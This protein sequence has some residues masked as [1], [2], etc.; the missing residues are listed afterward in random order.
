MTF[1]VL[2]ND[3]GSLARRGVLMTCHGDVQTPVFMP[4]GTQGT[5]KAMA[6]NELEEMGAEIILGNTY[7]LNLRPGMD[8]MSMAGG[9]HKFMAWNRA[10]LTDSGG[11]QVFSLSKLNKKTLDGVHFQSHIDGTP[12]FMGPVESMAIQRI[13]GSDIAM[14][15]DECT[16]YPISHS[17]AEK[18]LEMTLRWEKISAE[19]P[20]GEGQQV[21]GIV[22]GSVY[23]D[24]RRHSIEELSKM[25]FDGIA[26]GGVSVGESEEE[27]VKVLRFCGPLLPK[28]KPH[29]LMGVGTP[30]QIIIGVLNGIDMFDCV[31]PT[32]MGRNGSAYTPFGTIPIKAGRYK[33]DFS[34]IMEGCQCYACKHFTKAYI[35][36]LLNTNEILGSRLMSIHNLHYFINLMREIRL[37]LEKGTFSQLAEDVLKNYPEMTNGED[38]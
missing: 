30:R 25:P 9:L 5:V 10:I 21:F 27:M 8:I 19:Q 32:R 17:G 15:F 20:H 12:L 33:E 35:R 16:E 37:S 38:A 2:K 22:Q 18:S 34:P 26:V 11:Y 29:Y 31:L 23:E 36:H 14:A 1:S 4:V 24:L 3:D 7:H 28:E 13:I 6:P